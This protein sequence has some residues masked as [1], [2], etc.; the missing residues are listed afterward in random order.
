MHMKKMYQ[1]PDTDDI[2]NKHE[3]THKYVAYKPIYMFI[4]MRKVEERVGHKKIYEHNLAYKFKHVNTIF[5]L[6]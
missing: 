4:S 3:T 2:H 6:L 5:S 1:S